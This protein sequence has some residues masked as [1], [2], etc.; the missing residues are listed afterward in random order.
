MQ[1]LQKAQTG[2]RGTSSIT[3]KKAVSAERTLTCRVGDRNSCG[4]QTQ[5]ACQY[6]RCSTQATR[7]CH[8]AQRQCHAR[9]DSDLLYCRSSCRAA[10]ELKSDV[11]SHCLRDL[12]AFQKLTFCFVTI[13]RLCLPRAVPCPLARGPREIAVDCLWCFLSLLHCIKI[14]FVQTASKHSAY[15]QS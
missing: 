6:T 2:E 7:S 15:N 10:G 8:H 11:Q 5:H 4:C 9:M 1:K 13:D 3:V 12:E 14:L